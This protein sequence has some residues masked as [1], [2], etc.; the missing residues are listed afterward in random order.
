M[1]ET[2]KLMQ[3][4]SP[5]DGVVDDTPCVLELRP[6]ENIVGWGEGVEWRRDSRDCGCRGK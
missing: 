5:E 3:L 1:L 2:Y 6:G 4:F